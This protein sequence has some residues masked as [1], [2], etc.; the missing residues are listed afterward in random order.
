MSESVPVASIIIGER[1]RKDLG[2]IDALA[3][4]IETVGLL[5]P[6][7]VT[8][9]MHLVAGERRIEAVKILGWTEVPVTIADN[10]G[11]AREC[12]SAERAENTCRENL[13]PS[14][15]VAMGERLETL[16]RPEAAARK[17]QGQ[18]R[19]GHAR[20]GSLEPTLPQA[21]RAKTRDQAVGGEGISAIIEERR[22]DVM[23]GWSELVEAEMAAA[24]QACAG[25]PV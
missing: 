12:L 3:S 10:L 8:P 4:S 6:P 19:G 2:D 24:T 20:Q 11:D 15:L 14:E 16:Y 9:D 22:L 7:V 5:H 18:V 17:A 21:D 1:T 23:P 25:V 13:R